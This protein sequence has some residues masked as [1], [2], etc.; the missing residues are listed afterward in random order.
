MING[1]LKS[2]LFELPIAP[3]GKKWILFL[4]TFNTEPDDSVDE[5]PSEAFKPQ[6]SFLVVDRSVAV[7]ITKN[8]N[9]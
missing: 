3:K 2:H 9:D 1:D 4:N 6:K 5:N 7:F 8:E